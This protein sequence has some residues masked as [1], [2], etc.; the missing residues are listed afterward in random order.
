[1]S[2][3]PNMYGEVDKDGVPLSYA[4]G[5]LLSLTYRRKLAKVQGNSVTTFQHLHVTVTSFVGFGKAY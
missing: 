3:N 2:I 5:E 1:M 4:N